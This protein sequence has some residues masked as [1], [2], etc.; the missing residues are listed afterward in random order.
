[1]NTKCATCDAP[2]DTSEQLANI[3]NPNVYCTLNRSADHLSVA[4]VDCDQKFPD[5]QRLK[6]HASKLIWHD[7]ATF[8]DY[9]WRFHY[10]F[11]CT[12]EECS[13]KL[14]PPEARPHFKAKHPNVQ[15]LC[16]QC[17]FGCSSLKELD[18]HGE[19]TMHTPY[20]CGFL[21]CGAECTRSSDL[22]RHQLTHKS[23][24]PRHACPHCRK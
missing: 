18:L 16:A 24:V 21:D 9:H 10:S 23:I 14:A 12:I 7:K 17:G 13:A 20:T 4:C 1:M 6:S 11:R 15:Y 22:N 3:E 2:L 8:A 19:Q 5:L